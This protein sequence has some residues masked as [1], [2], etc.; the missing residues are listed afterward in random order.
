MM[1]LTSFLKEVLDDYGLDEED[2][3]VVDDNPKVLPMQRPKLFKSN[4]FSE[5]SA[6]T[7]N[8]SQSSYSL[9][10]SSSHST[11]QKWCPLTD[12][13]V[14]FA[15][16]TKNRWGHHSASSNTSSG[17]EI[18][19]LLSPVSVSADSRLALPAR[20]TSPYID[21]RPYIDRLLSPASSS[22][23]SIPALPSRR[24]G[25]LSPS[26][27]KNLKTPT[28]TGKTCDRLMSPPARRS[29]T[30]ESF[31]SFVPDLENDDRRK[32]DEKVEDKST[33]S[34]QASSLSSIP[35]VLNDGD[36]SDDYESDE[37]DSSD[38]SDDGD[39]SVATFEVT[40]PP[41]TLRK[42]IQGGISAAAE[43]PRCTPRRS[44]KSI[45]TPPKSTASSKSRI[46]D[47]PLIPVPFPS[48]PERTL[49]KHNN[50]FDLNKRK[51]ISELNKR[52]CNRR[53]S[54]VSNP[55]AVAALEAS[56]A[57]LL[58]SDS[59]H[60]HE[61]EEDNGEMDSDHDHEYSA[62]R[63]I[64]ET[65]VAAKDQAKADGLKNQACR[66]CVPVN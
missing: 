63:G 39:L 55:V 11:T 52:K 20:G 29:S 25:F 7:M 48:T 24:I 28:D 1:A 61:S 56:L 60:D 53:G 58:L 31:L 5:S 44:I 19:R 47:A 42:S 6:S 32:R 18:D 15:N 22:A 10:D 33:H 51:C 50:S 66:I 12:S 2:L 36:I 49:P 26:H 38:E 54:I 27:P 34:F 4:V 43:T 37:S 21:R 23:D 35:D 59:E 62:T 41:P 8:E 30:G 3:I 9:L 46:P 45:L 17:S 13:V 65:Q 64:P 14:G 40:P 16:T 57:D